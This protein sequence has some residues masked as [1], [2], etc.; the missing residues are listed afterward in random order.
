[1]DKP[2]LQTIPKNVKLDLIGLAVLEKNSEAVLI[3]CGE[4]RKRIEAA[5]P[6]ASQLI[7]DASFVRLLIDEHNSQAAKEVMADLASGVKTLEDCR[8]ALHG[9]SPE[10]KSALTTTLTYVRSVQV[11]LQSILPVV[12]GA[13]ETMLKGLVELGEVCTKRLPQHFPELAEESKT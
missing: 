12:D 10:Q 7:E 5:M 4:R 3:R 1:M 2:T 11:Y 6:G 13:D 8:A 9:L